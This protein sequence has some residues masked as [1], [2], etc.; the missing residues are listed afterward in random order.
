M[1]QSIT[2][3]SSCPQRVFTPAD[4]YPREGWVVERPVRGI[5]H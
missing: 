5:V 3:V 4:L 2:G 1:P